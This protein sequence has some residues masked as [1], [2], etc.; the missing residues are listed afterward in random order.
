L[1]T[2][3]QIFAADVFIIVN[4][5]NGPW[6]FKIGSRPR[7][8]GPTSS[9]STTATP[10][11]LKKSDQCAPKSKC[12]FQELIFLHSATQSCSPPPPQHLHARDS[13]YICTARGNGLLLLCHTVVFTSRTIIFFVTD[14]TPRLSSN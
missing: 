4:H 12:F 3:R 14:T 2:N 8:G 1:S 5:N 6:S 11:A 7:S 9:T 13:D 10:A